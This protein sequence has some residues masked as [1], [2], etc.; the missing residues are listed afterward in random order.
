M[1]DRYIK[2]FIDFTFTTVSKTPNMA[3]IME[4]GRVALENSPFKWYISFGTALGLERNGDFLSFDTDIDVSV[5]VGD[6]E[7]KIEELIEAFE[8]EFTFIRTVQVDDQH[9]Q[10]AFQDK[11]GMIF[12]LCF[13][14]PGYKEEY[15]T[16]LADVGSFHDKVDKITYKDTK[17]GKLPF[18][19]PIDEYLIMRYDEDWKTPKP[20]KSTKDLKI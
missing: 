19:D 11:S 15:T 7:D 17:Y 1:S 2:H 16:T 14:R 20:Q 12:D 18:P 10:A 13:Y 6:N 5:V 9:M 3:E 4:K 8:K